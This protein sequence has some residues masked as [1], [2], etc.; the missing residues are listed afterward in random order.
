MPD[1]PAAPILLNA[2]ALLPILE[3][4]D[5]R[6][7][8]V[9]APVD[10]ARIAEPGFQMS[11]AAVAALVVAAEATRPSGKGAVGHLNAIFVTSAVAS[12]ATLPVS[13]FHFGRATHYAVLGNLLAMPVMGYGCGWGFCLISVPLTDGLSVFLIRRLIPRSSSGSMVDGWMTL[14]P[15]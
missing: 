1:S 8:T 14:A 11:F 5:P 2:M 9:A 6:L 13:L 7:R 15:K 10:A 4:P 12:L 3:F